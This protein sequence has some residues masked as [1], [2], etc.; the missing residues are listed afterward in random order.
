[1]EYY[2]DNSRS[3]YDATN[4]IT[5][6]TEILKSNLC[7][8]NEAYIL[9]TGYVTVVAAPALQG[10]FKSFATFN[11]CIEKIDETAIDNAEDYANS[12]ANVQST[13]IEFKLFWINR[14]FMVFI[15]KMKQLILMQILLIMIILSINL[16]H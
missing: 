10:A 14:K 15:L 3:N 13:R 2:N 11:K 7:D 12:Y 9:V 4:G 1:M 5:Y 6:S 16:N 8:C